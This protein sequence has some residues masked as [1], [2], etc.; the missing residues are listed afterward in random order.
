MT[1]LDIGKEILQTGLGKPLEET[2]EPI[3]IKDKGIDKNVLYIGI[4]AGLLLMGGM[5]YLVFK[6]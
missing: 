5:F 1:L 4:F 2:P 3:E 6:K